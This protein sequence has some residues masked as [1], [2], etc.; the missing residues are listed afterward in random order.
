[1]NR[2]L[3]RFFRSQKKKLKNAGLFGENQK[4]NNL[5]RQCPAMMCQM[6]LQ[7]LTK[8]LLK[9]LS[10]AP[11]EQ[12]ASMSA[13]ACLRLRNKNFVFI[14]CLIFLCLAYAKTAG[15]MRDLPGA[16]QPN[17]GIGNA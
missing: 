11:T 9:K 7:M 6:T 16:I 12:N 13:R 14:S 10:V 15:I 4:K 17:S 1:M 8:A 2:L 3:A 5:M